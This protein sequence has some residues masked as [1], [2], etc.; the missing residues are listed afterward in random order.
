M[1]TLLPSPPTTPAT[2][3]GAFAAAATPAAAAT[4][5]PVVGSVHSWDLSTGVDGP[6][7]R[8]VA[9]LS[10]CPLTCL[11]CH[12][13]DTWRMRDGKRTTADE[14]VAEAGKYRRFI[15]AAGGGATVSGGE[16]LLQPVFT[17][18]LLHRFKHELG[19]HTALDTSGFLG[20]RATDALLRDTDL[21]LLDIK[22]WD[23]AIYRRVTGRPLDPTLD[24]ARRLADLGKEVHVRFVLVPGLTDAPENI[25]GVAAFA[26][27][28]GNVSRVDVLP[29]HKLGEAKWQALGRPFALH[30]T[31][32]PTP[33]Q[34]S[35]ARSIFET[36]GLRAV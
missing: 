24:L 18:E 20:V 33:E 29:F 6:G 9:F 3:G 35:L 21:V 2:G 13:P 23:R 10:G 12:N 26:A 7:T 36:H 4:R 5:R 19:L 34:V 27:S 11:Y 14:I 16:P 25:A 15:A 28:L 1:T 8:F 30:D 17:G 22:S 31:P 32:S